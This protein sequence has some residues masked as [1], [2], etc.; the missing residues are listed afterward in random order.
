MSETRNSFGRNPITRKC[1]N[2]NP[3]VDL[4]AMVSISFLLIVFFMLTS[5]LSR[6]NGLSLGMPSKRKCIYDRCPTTAYN[7]ECTILLKEDAII[8]YQGLL[9]SPLEK[10]KRFSY[11]N[12]GLAKEVM[13]KNTLI[14]KQSGNSKKG[15]ILLV[16]SSKQSNYG[17]LVHVLDQLTIAKTAIYNVMDITPAEELF[18]KDK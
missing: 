1:Q 3:R 7:R 5:F 13:R 4:T 18:L 14:Q 8:L 12:N 17:N 9:E 2:R 10:P 11:K 15:L 6:P 16:K